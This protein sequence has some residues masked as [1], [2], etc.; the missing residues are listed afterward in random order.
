[1]TDTLQNTKDFILYID[2]ESMNLD[3]FELTFREEFHIL[4]AQ[5][6]DQALEHLLNNPVKV[7]ISDLRM[8]EMSG[9]EFFIKIKEQYPDIIKI[10]LTAF[11]DTE[12]LIQSLNEGGIYRYIMKPWGETDL[13]FTINNAIESFNLK[14]K[15]EVLFQELK[16]YNQLLE[17]SRNKFITLVNHTVD[18]IYSCDNDGIITYISPSVANFGYS[19]SDLLGESIFII[20]HPDD[21]AFM[22]QELH[23]TF[24]EEREFVL[25]FRIQGKDG[26]LYVVE[27]SGRLITQV[28]GQKEL[29]GVIRNIT[30]RKRIEENLKMAKEKAEQSDRLKTAFLANLS[31]EIRTP[32]NGILGF[33]NLLVSL[34]ATEGVKDVYHNSIIN[35]CDQLLAVIDDILDISKMDADELEV[36][37]TQ[38]NLNR[39]LDEIYLVYNKK[40]SGKGLNLILDKGLPD[41]DTDI[42]IDRAKLGQVLNHLL[43]NALKFSQSGE[44]QYGYS[45]KKDDSKEYLD[46]FVKDE[47]I[48][49]EP[50]YFEQIFERFRQIDEGDNR[51]YGGTGL[52]LTIVKEMLGM[53]GGDIWLESEV[54]KGSSFYFRIPFGH[55]KKES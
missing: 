48:G 5:T 45:L 33:S 9:L 52:G 47:G 10:I 29:T 24:F 20:V 23:K 55:V 53:L 44:I 42:I 19:V 22:K 30:H 36:F 1:V 43:N 4:T 8:P 21:R 27:E 16:T 31:H 3:G 51:S 2:D 25:E 18:I 13:R 54:G 12:A 37:N 46:F 39:F 28:E 15:N 11:A 41:E 38:I 14:K 40:I 35:S 26:A 32:L 49:I 50:K 7:I 17:E 34:S 6:I